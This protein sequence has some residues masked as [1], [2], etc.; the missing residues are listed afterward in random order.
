MT[1]KPTSTF[2]YDN[3]ASSEGVALYW[4]EN[5]L[6]PQN[7]FVMVHRWSLEKRSEFVAHSLIFSD[8]NNSVTT[9]YVIA[10][11]KF[12]DYKNESKSWTYAIAVIKFSL[13]IH[14]SKLLQIRSPSVSRNTCHIVGVV[15]PQIVYR[16]IYCFSE[17]GYSWGRKK[18]SFQSFK[19]SLISN[20]GDEWMCR[21]SPVR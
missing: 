4:S 5:F 21:A 1:R 8:A 15:L 12:W 17:Q 19:H 11:S 10:S 9:G 18:L 2:H 13:K 3:I 6:Q 14:V 16:Q 7:R 20:V